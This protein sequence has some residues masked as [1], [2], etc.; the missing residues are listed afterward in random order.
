MTPHH[1]TK[2]FAGRLTCTIT[3]DPAKY[4]HGKQGYGPPD[5]Q[6]LPQPTEEEYA[7]FFPEY[8]EWIHGVYAAIAHIIQRPYGAILQDRRSQ[9]PHWEAWLYHPDGSKECVEQGDG[10]FPPYARRQN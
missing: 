2:T 10:L 9:R 6:W 1:F 8:C 3:F 4:S 7:A 5:K